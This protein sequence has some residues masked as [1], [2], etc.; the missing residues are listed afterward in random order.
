MKKAVLLLA[1][2]LVF[3][4]IGANAQEQ[5]EEVFLPDEGEQIEAVKPE[6]DK[7]IFNHLS[8]GVAP[9]DPST[10]VLPNVATTVTPYVQL[11]LGADWFPS[12]TWAGVTG[13]PYTLPSVKFGDNKYDISLDAK[14]NISAMKFFVDIFPTKRI[15]FHFTVGML[16]DVFA[17]GRLIEAYTTQPFL[18]NPSDYGTLGINI[19]EGRIATDK[20]GNLKVAVKANAVRPYI[21]IGF[22]RAVRPD[23]RVRVTFDMGAFY[24]GGFR[25][26]VPVQPELAPGVYN[27][28]DAAR[29]TKEL[30]SDDLAL[31]GEDYKNFDLIEAGT[32]PP[33]VESIVGTLFGLNVPFHA[34]DGVRKATRWSPYMKLT[35][36]INIF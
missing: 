36:Y 2:A 33:A 20:T 5:T 17:G 8:L 9:L 21:G 14:L 13:S 25:L 16:A 11:R 12:L 35:I 6:V 19:P 7:M 15:G 26:T 27:E 30:T 34:I 23:K 3:S 18:T 10:I 4:A 29:I 1:A 32:L 31:A 28:D 22:G 24:L